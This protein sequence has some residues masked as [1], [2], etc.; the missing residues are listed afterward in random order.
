M[1]EALGHQGGGYTGSGERAED[2]ALDTH[3]VA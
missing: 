2:G 3:F 1:N